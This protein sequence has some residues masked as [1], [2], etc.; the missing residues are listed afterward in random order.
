MQR[1]PLAM[2]PGSIK[3]EGDSNYPDLKKSDLTFAYMNRY[4]QPKVI[5]LFNSNT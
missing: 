4:V 3:V 5:V 1:L 2:S